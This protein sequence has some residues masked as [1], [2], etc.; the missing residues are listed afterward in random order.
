MTHAARPARKA[1]GDR[2]PRPASRTGALPAHRA[3]PHGYA[4]GARHLCFNSP[5]DAEDEDPFRRQEALQE[6]RHGQA[7]RPARLLEPHPREEVAEAQAAHRRGRSRSRRADRKRVKKLLGRAVVM[8]RATQRRRAAEAAQEDVLD[9]GQGL[10]RAQA[11]ELPAAK[12]QVMRSDAVRLP[13][14][15]QPQARLPP[16]LDHAHQRRRPARG[17][18]LLGAHPRPRR[19]RR[20]GQPQD[21]RRHRRPRPRGVPPICRARPGGR[22]APSRRQHSRRSPGRSARRAALFRFRTAAT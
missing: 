9:A 4:C 13:R 18:E 8:P 17:D 11:L 20:R 2:E 3:G 21:A 1:A 5:S 14:P 10:L 16:A 22:R 6:D 19:G 12:E 7:P 15:A